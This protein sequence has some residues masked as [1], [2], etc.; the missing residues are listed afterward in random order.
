MG[1]GEQ[2]HAA[3]TVTNQAP[4]DVE[5]PLRSQRGRGS[6]PGAAA[7]GLVVAQAA[8]K[9]HD[10][11]GADGA[12]QARKRERNSAEEEL[13][14]RARTI[15]NASTGINTAPVE[16]KGGVPGRNGAKAP[17]QAVQVAAL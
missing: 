10:S 3:A 4:F 11:T 12:P 8:H 13:R 14:N 6:S 7:P 17:S 16:S 15:F 1:G 5:N 9:R 2:W